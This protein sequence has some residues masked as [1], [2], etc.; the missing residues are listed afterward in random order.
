LI[1][2]QVQKEN[3]FTTI[4]NNQKAYFFSV[5]NKKRFFVRFF[6]S[7]DFHFFSFFNKIHLCFL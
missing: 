7:C 4:W 5:K 2:L 6:I 1:L 3:Y